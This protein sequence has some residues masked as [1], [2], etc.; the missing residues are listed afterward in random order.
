MFLFKTVAQVYERYV[1]KEFSRVDLE[2]LILDA[3]TQHNVEQ[4]LIG[5]TCLDIGLYVQ[6]V[7][8]HSIL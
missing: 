6:E 3:D 8:T 2:H 5:Q 1:H 4:V 7:L